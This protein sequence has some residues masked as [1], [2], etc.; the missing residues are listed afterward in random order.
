MDESLVHRPHG[1]LSQHLSPSD[2]DTD[3]SRE[4]DLLGSILGGLLALR[5]AGCVRA[6]LRVLI[7]PGHHGLQH[8]TAALW[9]LLAE[10]VPLGFL[11]LLGR[12]VLVA[13]GY[14]AGVDVTREIHAGV[15]E[16]RHAAAGL[17]FHDIWLQLVAGHGVGDCDVPALKW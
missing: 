2:L 4:S 17:D 7:V 16:G 13:A 14:A 8:V 5:L 15:L 6:V 10:L 11:A 3:E 1:R 9:L 12:L